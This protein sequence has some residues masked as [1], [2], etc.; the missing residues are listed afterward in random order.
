MG[1]LLSRLLR[2]NSQLKNL[3]VYTEM[4]QS[5]I[6][7]SAIFV[8]LTIEHKA[9]PKARKKM[10]SMESSMASRFCTEQVTFHS[11]GKEP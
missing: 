6:K 10:P 5:E 7:R 9:V 2:S 1:Y 4:S 8:L 3:L 11:H